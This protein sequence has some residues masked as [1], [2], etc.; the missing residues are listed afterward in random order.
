MRFKRQVVNE[1][2]QH[3]VEEY[4][5]ECCGIIA[6]KG[7]KQTVYRCENIQNRLHEED[8][9]SHPRDARTAYAIDRKEAERIYAEARA[10][11]EE[12]LAF[13]HSHTEHDAYF[14]EMD[15]E[16]QT[17]FGE[18]EFPD[19]VHIVISVRARKVC[20]IKC[21]VWDREKRNFVP[22]QTCI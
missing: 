15:K 22:A 11:N 5:D 2:S 13:Y 19:A 16:V 20:D 3:A 21:Y 17:V 4:P 9:V 6:G 7:S 12:V 8:P 10:N 14:S 18:P 1:I